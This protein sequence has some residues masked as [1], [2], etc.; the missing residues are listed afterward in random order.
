MEGKFKKKNGG[1]PTIPEDEKLS[2]IVSFRLDKSSQKLL[3]KKL[4][5]AKISLSDF[6]RKALKNSDISKAKYDDFLKAK[7]KLTETDILKIISIKSEVVSALTPEETKNIKQLYKFSQDVNTLVKRGNADYM[8]SH[9]GEVIDYS[10]EFENI[11]KE[12]DEIKE[13][14]LKIIAK[15]G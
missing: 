2:K 7:D 10:L 12:F 8:A 1:R 15:E 9:P 4:E 5:I 3:N 13:H 14:Y 11:K 6:I